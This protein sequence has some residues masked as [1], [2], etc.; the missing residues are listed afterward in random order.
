[1]RSEK[2]DGARAPGEI[3]KDGA[4]AQRAEEQGEAQTLRAIAHM[5]S[6][7]R[8]KF[9]CPRQSN[10]L[11]QIESLV[12]FEPDFRD[13]NALRGIERYSHL[14]LIW[15]FSRHRGAGWSPTVRPPRL[16]GNR[17]LGVFATRSPFRPNGL[18]LSSVRLLAVEWAGKEGP[19]LRVA[20][21]DLTDGTPIF[22]I[23]PYLPYTDS[24]PGAKG[25][26]TDDIEERR[27][28]VVDRLN[29][30]AALPEREQAELSALLS[31]D[32]RPSYAHEPEQ[33]YGLS[34]ANCNLRFRV[35]GRELIVLALE[36]E[37][38]AAPTSPEPGSAGDPPLP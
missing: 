5:R 2:N 12:V 11:P 3:G 35:A 23:K 30:L 16:G 38:A 28:R 26:F 25:G 34:Y 29:L 20:G 17:R 10:L 13:A 1:M 15:G 33:V 22:D 37:S 18:G 14:W 8:E 7:I 31:L 21:A 6:P 24:H 4:R 19:L 32:P 27:L 9:G 36:R